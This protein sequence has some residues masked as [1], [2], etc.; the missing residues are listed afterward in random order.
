METDTIRTGFSSV[1]MVTGGLK[2]SEVMVIAGRGRTGKTTLALSIA[3]NVAVDKKIPCAFFSMETTY[4][5]LTNRLIANI[6]NIDGDKIMNGQI[7]HDEWAKLDKHI[8]SLTGSPL[9][10]DDKPSLTIDELRDSVRKLSSEHGVRLFIIDSLQLINCHKYYFS[11][12][13]F[14][15]MNSLRELAD[16][17]KVTMVI[18]SILGVGTEE[19]H[20]YPKMSDH[21]EFMHSTILRTIPYFFI[22]QTTIMS[23]PSR[24]KQRE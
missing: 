6:C 5:K 23:R 3:K 9:Y 22:V 17:L 2:P 12:E 14:V 20:R 15:C 8:S 7:N 13:L 4:V 10:I 11:D 1:D 19:K 21:H 24:K 18:T 16:E